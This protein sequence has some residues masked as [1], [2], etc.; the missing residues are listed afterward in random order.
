MNF[1]AHIFLSQNSELLMIGNFIG[2]FVKGKKYLAY[3]KDIQKGILIH[4][5]IDYYT[6]THPVVKESINRLRPR[7][8][9]YSGIIVDIFYDHFLAANFDDYHPED[10][11]TFSQN[12]YKVFTNH[13]EVMPEKVQ[14]FLP[15]MVSQNWLLNYAQFWGIQKSLQGIDRRTLQP[16]QLELALHDLET[17]YQNFLSDFQ[18]FFP[19]IQEYVNGL[20]HQK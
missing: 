16:T 8:G 11:E 13:Q 15:Y 5:K 18:E 7:F 9:R 6:D 4:R 10:L 2:D 1:L 17:D 19:D 12:V 20:I 3:D 14:K